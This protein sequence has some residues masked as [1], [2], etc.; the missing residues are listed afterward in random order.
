MC[1]VVHQF[2][3]RKINMAAYK[4]SQTTNEH[5]HIHTLAKGATL[6]Q[7]QLFESIS[8]IFQQ[9]TDSR[10]LD[11]LIMLAPDGAMVGGFH[12]HNSE[13]NTVESPRCGCPWSPSKQILGSSWGYE[14]AWK[15]R[16]QHQKRDGTLIEAKIKHIFAN[17]VLVTIAGRESAQGS[18]L[19]CSSFHF[20]NTNQLCPYKGYPLR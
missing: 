5:T 20:H 8:N 15:Y 14:N 2:S 16:E 18:S 12:S 4:Y 13:G 9:L 1:Q 6:W 19:I 7:P 11:M 3:S 10:P 17:S